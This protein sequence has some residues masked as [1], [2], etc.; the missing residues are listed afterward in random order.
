MK[1]AAAGEYRKLAEKARAEINATKGDP[2]LSPQGREKRY[3]QLKRKHGVEVMRWGHVYCQMYRAEVEKARIAA[4]RELGKTAPKIDPVKL[5]RWE[6]EYKRTKTSLMLAS[7]VDRA[8]KILSDFI[9]KADEPGL[10]ALLVDR[11]GELAEKVLSIGNDPKVRA[12][13]AHQFEGLESEALT[14]EKAEAKQVLESVD[15]LEQA[16]V[17]NRVVEDNLSGLVGHEY[18]RFINNTD[19]FFSREGNAE[20]KPD[21]YEDP[22]LKQLNRKTSME[23]RGRR[24]AEQKEKKAQE[25]R[26]REIESIKWR[27]E[28]NEKFARIYDQNAADFTTEEYIEYAKDKADKCHAEVKALKEQLAELEG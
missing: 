13:M 19:S 7:S 28:H 23:A 14:P 2:D 16:K 21:D 22:E 5:D 18:G 8:A 27:I 24:V 20:H 17:F 9:G 6:K 11:Y 1:H 15:R 26:E 4:E 10:K 3:E 12:E 25:E